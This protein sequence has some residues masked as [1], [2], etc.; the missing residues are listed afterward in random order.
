MTCPICGED[1]GMTINNEP[2]CISCISQEFPM[3]NFH[4]AQ[5]DA[6]QHRNADIYPGPL[7]GIVIHE[8]AKPST[9]PR[10][11]LNY[12]TLT[13]GALLLFPLVYWVYG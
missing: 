2:F 12:P 13:L 6:W 8:P 10:V 5:T 7:C 3:S 1:P 4:N 9:R 11:R